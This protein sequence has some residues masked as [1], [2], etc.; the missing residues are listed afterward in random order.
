MTCELSMSIRV[1]IETRRIKYKIEITVSICPIR[2]S[3]WNIHTPNIDPK[4]PP[5]NRTLK[6][7][8]DATDV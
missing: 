3:L 5:N 4:K 1:P 6:E 8:E 7:F 2:T